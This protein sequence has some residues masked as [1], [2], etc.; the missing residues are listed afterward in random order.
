MAIFNSFSYVYKRVLWRWEPKYIRQIAKHAWCRTLSP[1]VLSMQCRKNSAMLLALSRSWYCLHAMMTIIPRIWGCFKCLS[2]FYDTGSLMPDWCAPCLQRWCVLFTSFQRAVCAVCFWL[3]LVA[4]RVSRC[5]LTP[6]VSLR[7]GIWFIRGCGWGG[8]KCH[9]WGYPEGLGQ[10]ARGEKGKGSGGS[11][12]KEGWP[13]G[14]EESFWG[15]NSGNHL[16]LHVWSHRR[17]GAGNQ[18]RP[19]E[20][21]C[22]CGHVS[23]ARDTPGWC[24]ENDGSSSEKSRC[25][26][27]GH[28][29]G[30]KASWASW[31]RLWCF[32]FFLEIYVLATPTMQWQ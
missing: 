24:F 17:H 8:Q 6:R 3:Q 12:L 28:G 18:E 4:W 30:V 14:W 5:G 20:R 15:S 13:Q 11:G 25:A 32:P 23:S 2:S 21:R 31:W 7:H 29:D 16:L 1:N 19:G 9:R 27:L 26:N 22:F 10:H